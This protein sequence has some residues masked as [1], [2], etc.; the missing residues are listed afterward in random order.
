MASASADN[1]LYVLVRASQ[2]TIKAS[3]VQ[4][5]L[6]LFIYIRQ[7]KILYQKIATGN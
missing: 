1:R 4:P 2:K 6:V 5:K 7:K 3:I